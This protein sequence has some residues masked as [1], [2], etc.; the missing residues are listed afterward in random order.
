MWLIDTV[1]RTRLIISTNGYFY[2]HTGKFFTPVIPLIGCRTVPARPC[3]TSIARTRPG[4]RGDVIIPFMRQFPAL[5]AACLVV[6]VSAC[7]PSTPGSGFT[8]SPP[9]ALTPYHTPT[10]TATPPPPAGPSATPLPSPTPTPRTHTVKQGETMGSIALAYGVSI[11]ALVAANPSVNPNLMSVGTVLVI[12]PPDENTLPPGAAPSPTPVS[13]SLGAVRCWSTREGGAWCFVPAS[14]LYPDPVE[15]VS[16]LVRVASADGVQL[17]AQAALGMT[18]LL[19]AGA[20]RPLAVYFAPPLSFPLQ[21]SAELLTALPVEPASQRYTSASLLNQQVQV[22]PNGLSAALGGEIALD[23]G[24]A[25]AGLVLI[26]LAAYDA[27]GAVVGVRQWQSTAGLQP[28]ASLPV[29]V[30]VYSVG[31]SIARVEAFIEA[32]P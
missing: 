18:N 13:I 7:A 15:S 31:G 16:A 29:R 4:W 32:I 22:A 24:A 9:P 8:A 17:G 12:P 6:L 14:N 1:Q 3:H 26:G 10:F 28:G 20:T 23:E 5:L 30:V 19:P 25:P 2:K 27:Q 21:A 11:T